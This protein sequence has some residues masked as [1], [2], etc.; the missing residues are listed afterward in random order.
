[1]IMLRPHYN[2]SSQVRKLFDTHVNINF[3]SLYL[4]VYFQVVCIKQ[5]QFPSDAE[6]VLQII[7]V[8]IKKR[9]PRTKA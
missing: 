9:G 5:P 6:A 7:D 8:Q 1:M 4:N 2:H 3:G